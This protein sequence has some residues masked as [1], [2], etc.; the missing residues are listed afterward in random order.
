MLANLILQFN[1]RNE[2]KEQQTNFLMVE[3][4]LEEKKY[5]SLVECQVNWEYDSLSIEMSN[6]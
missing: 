4:I 5:L 3:N 1:E 6:L 2:D